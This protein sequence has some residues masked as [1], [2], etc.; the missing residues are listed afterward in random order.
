M[1]TSEV[2]VAL[3]CS[4]PTALKEM[5]IL[6]ILGVCTQTDDDK[7]ALKDSDGKTFWQG[8]IIILSEDFKWFLGNECKKIRGIPVEPKQDTLSEL[9]F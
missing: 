5:E 2:E 4:K 9:P 6:K 1:T 8:K 3:K 7:D